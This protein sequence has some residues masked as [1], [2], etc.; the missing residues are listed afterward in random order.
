MNWKK[1]ALNALRWKM[2]VLGA[3]GGL[4]GSLLHESALL[5]PDGP[6][7]P[8]GRLLLAGAALG[9][10]LGVWLAPVNALLRHYLR[11]GLKA[12]L[13]GALLGALLG[14]LGAALRAG[15]LRSAA[16]LGSAW[17][18]ATPPVLAVAGLALML[19]LI[20]AAAGLAAG[21]VAERNGRVLR[22]GLLGLLGGAALGVPV[23]LV[24]EAAWGEAWLVLAALVGW[25]ALLAL[26]LHWWELRRA[27][28][29][30]RLLTGPGEDDIFPLAA[31]HM[32][33]GKHE[34]N[35]IPLLHFQEVYPYH[36]ELR[37]SA[38]HYDIVDNEQ[39]GVV[40]VNYRQ[41]QE[42]ALK[43]GDL[44][45]IGTALLQYGEAS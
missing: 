17:A 26:S 23:G 44:V 38:D 34:R 10:G 8:T 25:S 33:L 35:D 45:K 37:W 4:W 40:L 22:R 32:T 42:H 29:W 9:L 16:T 1:V 2:L 18:W 5:L 11:R 19:G 36:C 24:A 3:A 41:V 12:A 31:G 27:R 30:L 28:R 15:L 20:A 14:A 21:L 13:A 6:G 39:G 7:G 43:P